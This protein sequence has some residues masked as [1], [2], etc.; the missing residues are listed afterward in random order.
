MKRLFGKP[1][2]TWLIPAI[3]ASTL[4]V[5]TLFLPLWKME[6]VARQY[7]QR[8][9]MHAYGYKFVG[10]DISPYEDIREING[11]NHYIGMK[12]LEEVTEMQFF[13]PGLLALASGAVIISFVAWKRRWLQWLTVAAFW[14]VPVFFVADLQFW[15][16]R[17][18][19]TLDE[20]A[21]LDTGAFTPKVLGKT[22]V[23]NFHSETGF[24]SGFYL[25][26][27]AALIIT[28][29]PPALRMVANR[30][31][32]SAAT[33]PRPAADLAGQSTRAVRVGQHGRS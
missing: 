21:P 3:I 18:G 29:G 5:V 7:P 9:I 14:T 31:E 22:Q 13:I 20:K 1:E 11:L 32:R 10:D 27:A 25:M 6:L 8:L 4:L 24:E 17:Y 23:W 28:F 12:P 15:L 16:Y 26:I 30:R 19:H 33:E 2:G